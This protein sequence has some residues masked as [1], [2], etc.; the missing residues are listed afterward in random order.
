MK[1]ILVLFIVVFV[2]LL[3]T[4]NKSF[5]PIE[6]Q[7]NDAEKSKA[8]ALALV[9]SLKYKYLSVLNMATHEFANNKKIFLSDNNGNISLSK[10]GKDL[11]EV[12]ECLHSVAQSI[13][14]MN[15]VFN[16]Q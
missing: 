16:A 3:I 8:E 11:K 12:F 14:D 4:A 9:L 5:A 15:T 10:Q 1:N 6:F 7:Q 2:I 13:N